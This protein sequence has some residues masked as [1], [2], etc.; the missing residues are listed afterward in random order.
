MPRHLTRLP[1]LA[2]VSGSQG[3]GRIVENWNPVLCT[4]RSNR[5][6]IGTLA[7]EVNYDHGSGQIA[8][9]RFLAQRF[10]QQRRIHVPCFVVAV[11][12][13]R[14][15]AQIA[16]RIC[17]C[18]KR[19]SGAE[20]SIA[21]ANPKKAEAKVDSSSTASESDGRQT[22]DCLKL[23]L[24]SGEIGGRQW[25]ASSNRMPRRH[26]TVRCR[27]CEEQTVRCASFSDCLN[28]LGFRV[29]E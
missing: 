23:F 1:R 22:D 15:G 12:E 28:N 7:I 27:P 11:D 9:R 3:F 17:A 21:W 26:K 5:V 2:F 16:N 20:D 10:L 14:L 4:S 25:R 13:Y 29:Y 24:E 18:G 8:C 6:Q 19:E